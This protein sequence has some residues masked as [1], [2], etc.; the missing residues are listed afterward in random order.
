V[1]APGLLAALALGACASMPNGE[2]ARIPDYRA[3]LERY[4]ACVSLL[5]TLPPENLSC[6][7]ALQAERPWTGRELSDGVCWGWAA[8]DDPPAELEPFLQA[9]LAQKDPA[10]RAFCGP[11]D[12]GV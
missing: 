6:A 5:N 1:K 2:V 3:R 8:K 7:R 4:L 11:R 10:I 9:L 12:P